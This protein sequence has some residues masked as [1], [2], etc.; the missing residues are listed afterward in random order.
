MQSKNGFTLVEIMIVVAVIALLTALAI[1]WFRR[2]HEDTLNSRFANDLRIACH[3]VRA[4]NIKTGQYP[5]DRTPRQIPAGMDGY[6]AGMEWR[7]RTPIGGWWDWDFRQF[8]VWAGVSVYRPERNEE[9]M[10]RI[11]T[12][13]DDGNLGTGRFRRRPDGYIYILEE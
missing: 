7:E 13:L 12:M 9:E 4:Y 10:A 2:Y 8:G 5:P 6:L 11:D 3:A 1:P